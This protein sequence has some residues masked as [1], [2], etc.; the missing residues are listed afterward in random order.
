[1][2]AVQSALMLNTIIMHSQ[3]T[4]IWKVVGAQYITT[5][6]AYMGVIS[7]NLHTVIIDVVPMLLLILYTSTKGSA[8]EKSRPRQSLFRGRHL[9][10][11]TQEGYTV[12]TGSSGSGDDIQATGSSKWFVFWLCIAER[13]PVVLCA[14]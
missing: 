6:C 12:S 3:H 11:E 4:H 10:T 5:I 8:T 2:Q 13:S 7:N 1:M 9:N 14:R